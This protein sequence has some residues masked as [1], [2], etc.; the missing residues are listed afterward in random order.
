M[1]EERE[2]ETMN[3]ALVRGEAQSDGRSEGQLQDMVKGRE[4]NDSRENG[5]LVVSVR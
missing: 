1:C 5:F 2:G 4:R 3:K